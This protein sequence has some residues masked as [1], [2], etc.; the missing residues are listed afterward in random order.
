[1]R[2]RE[3]GGRGGLV[4]LAAGLMLSACGP[5]PVQAPPLDEARTPEDIRR[6]L[7]DIEG[8]S[9][10]EAHRARARAY[11][12]LREM[13]EG[14]AEELMRRGDA[15]DVAVLSGG[16]PA[17]AKAESAVRLARHFRERAESPAPGGRPFGGPLGEPLRRYTRLTAA[18]RFGEYASR[19]ELAAALER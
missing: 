4:L 3:A 17:A 14:P 9:D 16:A 10:V 7:D 1:M 2:V 6:L 15:A 5:R 13:G 19:P 11:R 8:R 12:R 18:S